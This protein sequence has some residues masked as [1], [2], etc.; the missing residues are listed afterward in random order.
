[1]VK[2]NYKPTSAFSPRAGRIYQII[3][4][5]VNNRTPYLQVVRTIEDELEKVKEDPKIKEEAKQ[6]RLLNEE[7]QDQVDNLS[8]EII[9]LAKMNKDYKSQLEVSLRADKKNAAT[10]DGLKE[11]VKKIESDNVKLAK[12]NKT[13]TADNKALTKKL[14]NAK[15]SATD[16]PRG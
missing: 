14:K 2:K 7:L 12:A 4:R 11:E 3:S 13:L 16:T 15:E 6:Q 1:M 9:H 8:K 5:A 10:I